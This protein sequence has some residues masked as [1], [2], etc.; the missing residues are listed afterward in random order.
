MG[1][2]DWPLCLLTKQSYSLYGCMKWSNYCILDVRAIYI[3]I[4]I[5]CSL[6]YTVPKLTVPVSRSI[7][8]DLRERIYHNREKVMT[9]TDI[10]VFAH[11]PLSSEPADRKLFPQPETRGKDQ[12]LNMEV[13]DPVLNVKLRQ[14]YSRSQYAGDTVSYHIMYCIAEKSPISPPG[15]IDDF[16]SHEFFFSV[17]Y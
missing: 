13:V 12:V 5:S 10:P 6:F 3:I 7:V 15:L 2:L 16:L 4:Y 8:Y 1:G 17:L 14:Y 11:S 9:R